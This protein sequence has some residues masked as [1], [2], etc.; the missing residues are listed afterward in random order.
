MRRK[1]AASLVMMILAIAGGILT[2]FPYL[3]M[4]ATSLKSQTEVYSS[5][6]SLIPHHIDWG[7][8]KEALQNAPIGRYMF[9]SILVS[10]ISTAGVTV[11]SLLA[12]YALSRMRFP[13][14]NFIFLI[15]LGTMMIPH[16]ATMIPNYILLNWFGWINSYQGLIVPFLVYPFGI[17]I[18]R[19]FM[20]SI[21]R[22]LEEAAMLDGCGRLMTL[23]KVILPISK[24]AIATVVIFTFTFMW[25][26]FFWPLVMTNTTEMRTMQVGLA[27]L[28]SQFPMDWP[29]L[30]SAT[31]LS[32]IPV[33]LIYFCFQ[34]F[35]VKGIASSGVKG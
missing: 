5:G 21:P 11:T 34:K 22:E 16:Q 1:K 9:N 23:L 6:L 3:W 18:I 19:N 17:F 13:G 8:F 26:D 27:T 25:N 10:V 35:F 33:F 14:R 31:V 7:G 20:L 29:M 24:P 15:I 30:M 32:S 12:G 28:K 4:L 2:L